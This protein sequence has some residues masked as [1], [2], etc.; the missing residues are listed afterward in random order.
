MIGQAARSHVRQ[1]GVNEF[2]QPGGVEPVGER[3]ALAVARVE[4]N[5]LNDTD[6][7]QGRE[8]LGQGAGVDAE[9]VPQ[10][11]DRQRRRL[12]QVVNDPPREGQHHGLE[13]EEG[14]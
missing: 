12:S 14:T 13:V 8:A 10:L 7:L 1:P 5:D 4:V 11:R 2:V 6:G 3:A 9:A